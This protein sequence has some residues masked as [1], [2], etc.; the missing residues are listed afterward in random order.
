[1]PL[2]APLAVALRAYKLLAFVEQLSC[3]LQA[4]SLGIDADQRLCAG[5][6]D[7]QP[8]IMAKEEAKPIDGIRFGYSCAS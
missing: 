7:E 5:K 6:A 3:P 8:G 2:S 4:L 1:M